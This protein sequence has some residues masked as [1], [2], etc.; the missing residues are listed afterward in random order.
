MRKI[1]FV[2]GTRPEIIKTAPVIK[3]F[4]KD[5]RYQVKTCFSGQHQTMAMQMIDDFGLCIDYDLKLMKPGQTLNYLVSAAF[6]KINS[7]YERFRPDIVFVQGDTTTAFCA[8]L[9]G[10]YKK[11]KIAHIEAGLRTYDR[12]HPYPEEINRQMISRVTDLHFAPTRK[13]KRQL[14]KE[15][16]PEGSIV[17][18]GNT[19]IDALF[20][21]KK[22]KKNFTSS[23]LKRFPTGKKLILVTAHRRENFG[24][25]LRNICAAL[26]FLA[27][28]NDNIIII[29]PVHLNPNVYKVVHSILGRTKNI[30]LTKPLDYGD[31]TLLMDKSYFILTDS[32]GVQEEAPS[33]GKPVLVLRDKTERPEVVDAGCAKVIGTDTKKIIKF[34]EMILNSRICYKRMALKKNPVGDGHAALRIKKKVDGTWSRNE[35]RGKR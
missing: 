33:L 7:V 13:A 16:A 18:T 20:Y 22:N 32:G 4:K 15:G 14:I 23:F 6:Q 17:V 27:E 2:F 3:V 24:R 25:P 28:K 30:I 34:S 9:A 35:L 10:F 1:L 31:F 21:I 19:V 12:Y 29:Y 8:A 26:K 11:I 5:R